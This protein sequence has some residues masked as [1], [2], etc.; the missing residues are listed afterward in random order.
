MIQQGHSAKR[1]FHY[2][3]FI[4]KAIDLLAS[5]IR[6]IIHHQAIFPGSGFPV[7]GAVIIAPD[8][9]LDLFKLH[10]VPDLPDPFY[11]CF[12]QAVADSQQLVTPHLHIRRI[13]FHHLL[14]R[15]N[16]PAFYQLQRAMHIDIDIFKNI[17]TPWWLALR[18][19]SS[20][21]F[22]MPVNPDFFDP[23]SFLELYRQFINNTCTDRKRVMIEQ[24][25]QQTLLSSPILNRSAVIRFSI[26]PILFTINKQWHQST[27]AINSN[28]S[29]RSANTKQCRE[30]ITQ[31][32]NHRRRS[33]D[34]VNDVI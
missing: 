27:T 17:F 26:N 9:F 18:I 28:K 6:I 30:K 3:P 21:A 2:P 13:Y 4:D 34:V 11:S 29:I 8:I 32:K 14:C 25:D 1:H 12:L 19:Y 10:A 16:I 33:G 20:L 31:H 22:C 15:K 23:F 24:P 5:F 7:D